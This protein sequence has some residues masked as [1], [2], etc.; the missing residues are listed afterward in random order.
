[1]LQAAESFIVFVLL[2]ASGT[3]RLKDL[4]LS[5]KVVDEEAKA[6]WARIVPTPVVVVLLVTPCL[7]IEEK[8]SPL[9]VEGS[10]SYG[11]VIERFRVFDLMQG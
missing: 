5:V 8:L 10:W 9:K 11:R 3:V 7:R 1:M 2:P 6:A 4:W